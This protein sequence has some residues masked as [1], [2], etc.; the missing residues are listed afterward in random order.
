MQDLHFS[1]SPTISPAFCRISIFSPFIWVHDDRLWVWHQSSWICAQTHSLTYVFL[2]E[3]NWMEL[4]C[5]SSQCGSTCSRPSYSHSE[6]GPSRSAC[7][8]I[9][10]SERNEWNGMTQTHRGENEMCYIV[11]SL[12]LAALMPCPEVCLAGMLFSA[13]GWCP[14]RH[15]WVQFSL[16]QHFGPLSS[17]KRL[18][19]T[20]GRST[21]PVR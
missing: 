7:S 18:P 19:F 21:A 3:C 20:Q 17:C 4:N 16:I 1:R 11:I 5:F 10:C 8:R 15:G 6:C 13:W 12:P 2:F 14:V 9:Y